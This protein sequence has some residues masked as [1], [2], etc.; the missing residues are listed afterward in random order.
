MDRRAIEESQTVSTACGT[1]IGLTLEHGRREMTRAVLESVGLAI[2]DVVEVMEGKC[3]SVEDMR[4]TGGQA[5]S[6]FWSQVKVET[7]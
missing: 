3:L 6:P 7:E 4:V 1:F 2:R 5:R